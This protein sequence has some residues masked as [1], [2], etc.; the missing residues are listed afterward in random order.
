M[1]SPAGFGERGG[2][3]GGPNAFTHIPGAASQLLFSACWAVSVIYCPKHS[4]LFLSLL[5]YRC[6]VRLVCDP[7]ATV[8][9]NA[10]FVFVQNRLRTT[11]CLIVL[12]FCF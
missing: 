2:V 11:S 7:G 5:P 12:V 10:R 8:V 3:A 1:Q 6:T 9:Q 4:L